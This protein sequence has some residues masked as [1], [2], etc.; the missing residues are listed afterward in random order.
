MDIGLIGGGIADLPEGFYYPTL[1]QGKDTV[2]DYLAPM[3]FNRIA[4]GDGIKVETANAYR[5]TVAR[6]NDRNLKEVKQ[7]YLALKNCADAT[8][9]AIFL[10]HTLGISKNYGTIG[11]APTAL[12]AA[13]LNEPRSPRE[14][15]QVWGTQYRRWHCGEDYWV[16]QGYALMEKSRGASHIITDVRMANE[17]V[18]MREEGGYLVRIYLEGSEKPLTGDEH[19]SETCLLDEP[20]DY[21]LV[22]RPNDFEGLYRQVD[23]MLAHFKHLERRG[24]SPRST[25]ANALV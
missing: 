21:V 24:G 8:Y 18:K 15:T 3:G 12:I 22:N 4:F 5:T 9:V 19:E 23:A 14:I 13:A 20:V 11:N 7:P 10:E 2:A 16:N 25:R 6:L 17:P 1:G